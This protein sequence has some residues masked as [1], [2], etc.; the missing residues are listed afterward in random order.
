MKFF[1]LNNLKNTP[2]LG[3]EGFI[4]GHSIKIGTAS[5]MNMKSPTIVDGH[6]II[7]EI[8]GIKKDVLYYAAASGRP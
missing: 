5:F 7:Y 2:D 4:E 8:D 3:A 6:G 1:R